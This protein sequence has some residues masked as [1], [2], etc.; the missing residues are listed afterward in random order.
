MLFALAESYLYPFILIVSAVAVIVAP[1][2]AVEFTLAV[3]KTLF[4]PFSK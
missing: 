2:V 4:V 3:F 1:N